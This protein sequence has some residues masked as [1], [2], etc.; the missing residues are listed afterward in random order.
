MSKDN[1]KAVVPA[2]PQHVSKPL[3]FNTE[4]VQVIKDQLAKGVSDAE[5]GFFL[6]VC[7]ATGL[8]PLRR[9]IHAV[10][11]W[12]AKEQRE[13]MTIQTGIDGLR[14]QAETSGDYAGQRGP[15]WCGEDGTWKDVWLSD[16]PPAAAKIE[17]LRHGFS[18]PLVHI[19]KFSSYCQTFFNKKTGR[20][21]PM[22]LWSTMPEQQLAKCAE[23]G[24]LRRAFPRNLK[25]LYI[26]EE[27]DQM[28]NDAPPEIRQ[29]RMAARALTAPDSSVPDDVAQRIRDAAH[30]VNVS[31]EVANSR[32]S[33]LSAEWDS[34]KGDA[35]R[36]AAID[37]I[38]QPWRE[39]YK[40]RMAESRAKSTSRRMAGGPKPEPEE[41]LA[42]P[43]APQHSATETP[44]HFRAANPWA[45]GNVDPAEYGA[46]SRAVASRGGKSNSAEDFVDGINPDVDETEEFLGHQPGDESV[47]EFEDEPF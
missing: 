7:K 13:I 10:M 12:S 24:G 16:K 27:L 32:I 39:A 43:P 30:K 21:E 11:R 45:D 46:A 33:E 19:V 2:G 17:I 28:E 4:Q 37:K 1:N 20:R 9:E 31:Q 40:K 42:E 29:Q 26:A 22:G 36:N 15:F 3:E 23:A 41:P 47:E 14:T 8:D 5:L 6:E 38:L 34:L 25:G 18:E 44:D 35:A